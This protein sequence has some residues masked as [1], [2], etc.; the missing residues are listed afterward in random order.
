MADIRLNTTLVHEPLVD[1][2]TGE[3]TPRWRIYFRDNDAAVSI[4]QAV[5]V[6]PLSL[7]TKNSSIGITPLPTGALSPGLYAV[8][9]YAQ[10]VTPAGVSSSLTVA[11]NWTDHGVAQTY[12]GA[13][14]VGNTSATN[15]SDGPRLIRIDQG[16]PISYTVIYA[17]NP[18]GTMTYDLDLAITAVSR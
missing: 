6:A 13:A 10:I 16:S 8:T 12:T 4:A 17:S 18:A 7:T 1:L 5:V 14:L 15:Q 3:V 2:Q 11:V 9:W